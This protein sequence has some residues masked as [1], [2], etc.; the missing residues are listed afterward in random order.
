[1][2]SQVEVETE[3]LCY[4]SMYSSLLQY[5]NYFLKKNLHLVTPDCGPTH[6]QGLLSCW[7]LS[8]WQLG[9]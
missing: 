4:S 3:K 8:S 9:I 6:N 2:W 7:L 1:M 5:K